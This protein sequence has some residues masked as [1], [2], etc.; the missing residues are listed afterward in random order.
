MDAVSDFMGIIAARASAA[1][2]QNPEDYFVDGILFCGKCKTPKQC[3]PFHGSDVTVSCTCKCA[4]EDD[5]RMMAT[6]RSGGTDS[7]RDSCFR[8]YDGKLKDDRF[9]T[10]GAD[11]AKNTPAS[12]AARGYTKNPDGWLLL[13]G[14]TGTGKSYYAACICNA[15]IDRGYRC[16][17][18]SI[19]EIADALFGAE[20]KSAVYDDLAKHS[21]V[22]IDDLGAERSTEYMKEITFRVIDYLL[23]CGV[24]VVIT[25][26]KSLKEMMNEQDTDYQRIYSRICKAAIPVPVTGKDRRR[27]ELIA[28]A[29]GRMQKLIE[30]GENASEDPRTASDMQ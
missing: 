11:D 27:E 12:K 1:N 9:A 23:R 5:L 8:G 16:K 7:A 20:N 13:C 30:E 14:N 10:F 4:A 19:P 22:V 28:T 2:P 18:T 15:M 17:F 29:R 21:L 24:R 6:I 3:R 25:T 26:N